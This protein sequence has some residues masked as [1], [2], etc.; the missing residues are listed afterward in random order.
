MINKKQ[1]RGFCNAAFMNVVRWRLVEKLKETG[2]PVSVTY[3][4]E[5]KSKRI[6]LGLE[7]S[8]SND[9]FC[10]ADGTTQ[11]RAECLH[12]VQTRRNNRSLEKFYDAKYI[13]R[14]T[15]K[16]ASGSELHC[17]RTTRNKTKNG[18]NLKIYRERKVSKGRRSI[19]R[20]HY[21]YH[22]NDVVHYN[23]QL[24]TVKGVHCNG[25]R[26]MLKENNKSVKITDVKIYSWCNNFYLAYKSTLRSGDI[27]CHY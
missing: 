9:A 1:T 17:G 4:C 7:K 23:N 22:P 14:R 21:K 19:R 6:A 12:F 16:K 26:I 18:E 2:L 10:I 5:T 11:T 15:G 8:H 27:S 3:G 13:D 24:Y 20:E 25:N